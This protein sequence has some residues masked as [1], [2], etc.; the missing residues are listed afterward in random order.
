MKI[1]DRTPF[2]NESGQIDIFGRMQGTLKFGLNWYAHV[3]AQDAVIA[4]LEKILG[5]EFYLLRNITLPDTEIELPMVLIGPPGIFLINVTNERGVYRARDDEW[6]TVSGEKFVP[7]GINQVQ[8]A[9]KLG[10]V[11]QLYLDRAGYKDTLVVDPVL[12]ASDPGMHIESVRSAARIVMSDA[13]ERFAISMNQTRPMFTLAKVVEIA[14][15]IV[16]GPKKSEP[17]DQS[18]ASSIASN[19]DNSEGLTSQAEDTVPSFSPDTLGFSFDEQR[20]DPSVPSQL[21]PGGATDGAPQDQ[22][23][24]SAFFRDYDESYNNP[25]EA[26]SQFSESTE[27]TTPVRPFTELEQE[28]ES[29]DPAGL[30]AQ[31]EASATPANA[32]PRKSGLFGMTT[33]QIIFLGALLLFWLCSMAGFAIFIYMNR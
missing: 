12:M 21:Q 9:V 3:K 15:V 33:P 13:L 5:P 28:P 19:P 25:N 1:A 20:Q 14:R 18:S 31:T 26:G 7:A 23:S 27:P 2:R 11:L 6:G 4:V 8:R 10:R 30:E 17:A 22:G 29:F 32:A 24:M 16:K